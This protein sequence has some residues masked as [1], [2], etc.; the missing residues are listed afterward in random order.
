MGST[1]S[2]IA[3]SSGSSRVIELVPVPKYNH[4]RFYTFI[5]E[6]KDSVCLHLAYLHYGLTD[7]ATDNSCTMQGRETCVAQ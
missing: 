3:M 6:R 4:K 2:A 1:Y 7:P 5:D